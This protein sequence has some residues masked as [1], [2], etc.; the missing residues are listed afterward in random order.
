[1]RRSVWGKPARFP[2][3]APIVMTLAAIAAIA[4]A[5][6][7]LRPVPPPLTGHAAAVDGDTLRLAATRIRL[8]GLDAPELDQTC[9]TGG[10]QW[11]C[12]SEA[13]AFLAALVDRRTTNCD[14]SGRDRYGRVL[15]KCRVDG[16][17]LGAA[18]VAAGW[19]VTDFDYGVEEAT[20][21]AA[22]RGIWA[23]D[24]ATP[25][26]W[27]RSH[28]GGEPGLWEWLRSWFQ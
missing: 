4:V 12:G 22:R 20:A 19:A 3:F 9:S 2:R 10:R 16:D 6:S 27:R 14:P 24:F 15:A 21:R 7:W 13:R 1:M 25:A 28:G 23:G 5:T 8:T 26:E 17:D 18:I 11:N